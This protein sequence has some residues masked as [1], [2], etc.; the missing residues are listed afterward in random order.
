MSVLYLTSW[1]E[2][3]NPSR[4]KELI[5]CLVKTVDSSEVDHVHLLAEV[6][7]PFRHEKMSFKLIGIRPTYD[8]FFKRANEIGQE[9]D[10]IVIANTDIY[11]GTGSGSFVQR[12]G[13][14]EC[15]ALS[16]WDEDEE[17]NIT[18]FERVDSQDAWAFR[19]PIRKNIH[20]GFN[21][22]IPGC[23][24]RIAHELNEAGYRVL[25]PSK[26]V[27]F[28][29][30]HNSRVRNY[31]PGKHSIPP[32]YLRV[33]PDH[34]RPTVSDID[35]SITGVLHVGFDQPPLERAFAKAYRD[36]SFIRWTDYKD[37]A[38]L[39][40]EIYTRFLTGKYQMV[41]F[42]VQTAGVI[43][44]DLIQVMKNSEVVMNPVFI[45]WTGDVRAPLPEWYITLG[46]E[47]TMTL[48]SNDT[49]AKE[50]RRRGIKAEYLQIGF[51]SRI[52]TPAPAKNWW[53]DIV[54]LGNNY[55]G[56]FPLSP[57]RMDMVKLLRNHYGS[58]FGCYG[59]NWDKLADANLMNNPDAEVDCLRGCK[60]AI[61]LSHFDYERYSSDR[62]LRIL[63]SGAFC[64]T[65]RYPRME[66]EFTPGETVGVWDN[67]NEL[68]EQ[69]DHFLGS[70]EDREQ[71]AINGSQLAHCCHTWEVRLE[72]LK[73]YINAER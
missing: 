10:I 72:E 9:G 63:G 41:F 55:P 16:R 34:I 8:T 13:S 65:K 59:G 1:Y 4:R 64:L 6:E 25:N 24:N 53:P 17:G 36:Y 20:G 2:E 50:A 73:H 62:I 60:I 47:M 46:K 5:S 67:L 69:I 7:P 18:L 15:Y 19:Y 40:K 11:P 58:R 21:I 27:R 14:N 32:P 45:N 66:E 35:N 23:D 37:Y 61:N 56:K 30:R 43:T 31:V 22:G 51:D 49:D 44:P 54:F 33:T 28:I 3:K 38:A 12:L 29:H 48:F 57:L 71:I 68:T 26:D 42:H 39:G 52:F 70:D